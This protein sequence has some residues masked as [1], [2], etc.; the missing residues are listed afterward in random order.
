MVAASLQVLSFRYSVQEGKYGGGKAGD[1][2]FYATIQNYVMQLLGLYQ[3]S[4]PAL[5][6]SSTRR[7]YAL[8]SWALTL[9]S[10]VCST[11]AVAYYFKSVAWSQLL[12][13]IGTSLQAG[14]ILQLIWIV[15]DNAR[16]DRFD[17]KEL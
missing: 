1:S 11:V 4:L 5:R 10:L 9:G 14:V 6:N 16:G 2:D 12:G 13:F 7:S 3:T 15:D 8:W 17:Q